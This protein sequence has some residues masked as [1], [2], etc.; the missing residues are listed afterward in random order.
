MSE[1]IPELGEFVLATV[2]QI[3]TYGV[4]V[5]LDEYN[6]MK[7]FLHRSEVATGRIRRIGRFIR[8]GQKEVLKV[9]RVNRERREV[10]LSLKQIT[11]QE[12]KDKLI[13]VKHYD[14]AQNII[15]IAKN[16][17][18]LSQSESD[19]YQSILEDNFDT[20]Y[21]A[22]ENLSREGSKVISNLGLP[23]NY[24]DYIEEIAK[25]KISPPK[26]SIKSIMEVSSPLPNGI[27]VVKA[28]LSEAEQKSSSNT[29][30]KISYLCAPKYR[31]VVEA[32]DYKEAEKVLKNVVDVVQ[33]KMKKR[34]T[35]QISRNKN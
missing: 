9:I 18:K 25:E 33:S 22:M 34:G 1:E 30:I 16:G 7:G 8:V 12:K 23:K 35:F 24:V 32:T 31:L 17:L 26:V 14:K 28:A 27:E 20:L 2:K 19:D 10:N 29:E 13:D 21:Q 11:K 4:Y 6:E 5:S 3:T 15:D